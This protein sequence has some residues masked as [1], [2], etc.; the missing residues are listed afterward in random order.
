MTLADDIL[1]KLQADVSLDPS[2]TI[3]MNTDLLMTGLVDS[4]GLLGFVSWLEERLDCPIDP[5]DIILEHF[6]TPELIVRFAMT[7][8]P[9]SSA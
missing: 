8:L 4:L 1:E 2:V 5:G 9:I 3:E 7:L 6:E